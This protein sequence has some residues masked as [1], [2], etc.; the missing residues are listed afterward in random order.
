MKK[1]KLLSALSLVLLVLTCSNRLSAQPVS[2]VYLG[3]MNQFLMEMDDYYTGIMQIPL[4]NIAA[5]MQQFTPLM[6][7]ACGYPDPL[8]V[9]A[10]SN[11]AI[12]FDWP[13]VSSATQYRV[14][15]LNLKTGASDVGII[16]GSAHDFNPLPNGLYLFAFQAS[17]GGNNWG[18]TSII[19]VDKVVHMEVDDRIGCRCENGIYQVTQLSSGD[20]FQLQD[21]PAFKLN[22]LNTANEVVYAAFF[23]QFLNTDGDGPPS[24]YI[25][26]NCGLLPLEYL[27]GAMYPDSE[28]PNTLLFYAYG[29]AYVIELSDNFS[30]AV[31]A[32]VCK[33]SAKSR[34]AM[35]AEVMMDESPDA[36]F[37]MPFIDELSVMLPKSDG[38]SV[39]F[40]LKDL[41]GR[42]WP[43]I[44][45]SSGALNGSYRFDTHLLPSGIYL[46]KIK[47]AGYER[48]H[49]LVKS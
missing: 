1:M 15:Y 24:F 42:A 21:Y 14:G 20:I 16:S 7:P 28:D 6:P 31:Q 30:Y 40:T 11:T 18:K 34:D 23:K 9:T 37:P 10:M 36:L 12:A 38:A 2:P 25:N 19:I 48:I 47:T 29:N 45:Y 46:L 4:A 49:K 17:C 8:S 5:Y 33:K 41:V 26:P 22:L 13:D 43:L 35:N 27:T 39:D 44:A 3:N 32:I